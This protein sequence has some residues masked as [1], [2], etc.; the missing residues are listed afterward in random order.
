MGRSLWTEN[1]FNQADNRS[2]SL[3]AVPSSV[4]LVLSSVISV[5]LFS[6]LQIY[7]PLLSSTQSATILG[8]FIAS[9]LFLFSLTAVSNLE[10]VLL[11]KDFQAKIFPEVFVCLV[12]STVAAGMVHRVCLTTW[13]VACWIVFQNLQLIIYSFQ[14][15]LFP[16]R[17]VLREPGIAKGQH[18][19]SPSRIC[20]FE[21]E[22]EVEG[23]SWRGGVLTNLILEF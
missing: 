17:L 14:P 21:K 12:L 2:I 5:L 23:Y 13:W 6:L 11:G 3:S 18:V 20:A 15:H 10:T 8:G 19:F 1:W 22:E 16:N 7:K 9:W 4:S